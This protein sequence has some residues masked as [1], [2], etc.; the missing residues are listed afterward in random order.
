[1]S[2]STKSHIFLYGG[3][4]K[5]AAAGAYR[6]DEAPVGDGAPEVAG[7]GADGAV[8]ERLERR[9]HGEIRYPRQLK[10]PAR[11]HI[12]NHRIEFEKTRQKS[13]EAI[14]TGRGGV[15]RVSTSQGREAG[16]PGAAFVNGGG[17]RGRRVDERG[18]G[19]G[20]RT[21]ECQ[22]FSGGDEWLENGE[23]WGFWMCG[24]PTLSSQGILR[25]RRFFLDKF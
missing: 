5:L 8:Q 6:D 20:W 2:Q 14:S 12:Q 25:S 4:T 13:G 19:I 17:G 7:L 15:P 9:R 10:S 22:G 21:G 24:A 1:M 16:I 18:R 3:K 23:Y 11:A